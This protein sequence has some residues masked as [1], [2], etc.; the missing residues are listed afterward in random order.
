MP[1]S[2]NLC[3]R[4][5]DHGVD[6]VVAVCGTDRD[7]DLARQLSTMRLKTEEESENENPDRA[8]RSRETA[9]A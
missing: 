6:Q 9:A 7:R 2:R 5:F 8:C 4:A 1:R 3:A